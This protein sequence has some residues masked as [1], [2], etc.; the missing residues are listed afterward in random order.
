MFDAEGERRERPHGPEPGRTPRAKRQESR[1]EERKGGEVVELAVM[2][3]DEDRDGAQGVHERPRACAPHPGLAGEQ[4]DEDRVP[5]SASARKPR[6]TKWSGH[7]AAAES[8]RK[9]ARIRN[10]SGP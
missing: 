7:P 3:D 5:T 8:P 4:P 6:T 2:A 10:Q 9:S 1:E